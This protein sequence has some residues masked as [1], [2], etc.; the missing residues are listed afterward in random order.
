MIKKLLKNVTQRN[1]WIFKTCDKSITKDKMPT[2]AHN[3]GLRHCP[4]IK[5]IEILCPLEVM[6]VS[7]IIPFS[8]LIKRKVHNMDYKNIVF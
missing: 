8:L 6:L 2:Q 5:R 4:Y 1:L 7:Q 3:N